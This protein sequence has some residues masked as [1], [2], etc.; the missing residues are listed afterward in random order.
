MEILGLED[1]NNLKEKN[2]IPFGKEWLNMDFIHCGAHFKF[3]CKLFYILFDITV[4][5]S[6]VL[7]QKGSGR[8]CPPFSPEFLGGMMVWYLQTCVR[9]TWKK[10][11]V[12]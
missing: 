9:Y 8:H 11:A 6:Q 5:D 4:W 12:D 3:S 1:M 2:L 10:G 7:T